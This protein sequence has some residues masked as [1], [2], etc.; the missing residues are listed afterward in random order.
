MEGSK[1]IE[2]R[3]EKIIKWIKNPY[4]LAFLGVLIF[5]IIIRIYYFFLTYNQALWWDEAEYMSMAKAW[6]FGWDYTF[7]T[8]RPILFSFISSLFL[9]ISVSEFLPRIFILLISMST[10]IGIY[11]LGKEIFDRKIGIVSALF[12]S[13]F[14]L[15]LFFTYRL[16][17]DLVSLAFYTFSAF[18][19]YRYFIKKS[20]IS[21][22]VGTVLIGIGTMFRIPTVALL[23]AIVIYALITERLKLFKLKEVW[24][25]V[26]LFFLTISP[27]I[28]WG[29]IKFGKFVILEAGKWNAPKENILSGGIST[30]MNYIFLFPVYLSWIGL[31]IFV[32]GLF[33]MY[34]LFIG[35]DL[36]FK[37]DNTEI[38]K[39]LYLILILIFPI[40]LISFSLHV[41]EDRYI[42]NSFPA[43]FIISGY[44]ILTL[45]HFLK[46][47]IGKIIVILIIIFLLGYLS[48]FQIHSGDSLIKNKLSSYYPVKEAGLWLKQNSKFSDKILS[49]S[50]PQ[51]E[52]YSERKTLMI[53]SD[54]E[55]LKSLVSSDK[56]F[57][58]YVVSIFEG[59]DNWMYSFPQEE[60][61]TIAQIYFTDLTKKQ[62]SLIVYNLR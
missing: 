22:Y 36:L 62:P 37:E 4:N 33:A 15:N 51:I 13:V 58:F 43:I 28:I 56:N 55:E 46:G 54:K 9:R 20:V 26:I 10:I 59:H 41:N 34:K 47:K 18:F 5:A 44:F 35:F 45:Y 24:V 1:I 11:L 25:S 16:L 3:K 42:L 40:L 27:Y 52:Y 17:V 29:Y 49:K 30:L 6:A 8:V 23:F 39:Y 48:Y 57:K 2:Y 19:F 61:L 32:L 21:L 50:W 31:I 14:Y 38:K 12:M 53:P 60:N 7:L